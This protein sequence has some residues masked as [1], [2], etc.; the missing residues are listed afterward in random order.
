[1]NREG[2]GRKKIRLERQ[3]GFLK[4]GESGEKVRRILNDEYKLIRGNYV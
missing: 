4:K 1:M 2:V 3:V